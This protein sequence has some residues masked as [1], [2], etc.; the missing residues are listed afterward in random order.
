MLPF[1]AENI[2]NIFLI[3]SVVLHQSA[4]NQNANFFDPILQIAACDVQQPSSEDLGEGEQKVQ[5]TKTTHP[6]L[7]PSNWNTPWADTAGI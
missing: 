5:W 1:I 3:N 6:S 7:E 2:I 4:V